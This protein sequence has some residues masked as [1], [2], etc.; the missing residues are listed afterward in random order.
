MVANPPRIKP[1]ITQ[2]TSNFTQ[3]HIGPN[4]D[5]VQQMLDILGLSS[6]DDLIDKTVPQ[7]IRFHQT[8]NLPA[9]QSEY[10]ALG[11]LKQIADKNQ[12]YRSF[13]GMG[14]YDCIT[15]AVIQRN[16][17]ENPG[18]YT[19][20]TPY[21]PEIAQGRLEALL[22]FQT[23]I[24]DLTGLEIANAS[25]LDEGTAAAEAM[26]MSYGVC[27]NKSHNYFVS[28]ECHPQT[29]DVLQTRAKP[30]GINIIIGDH[31][32][33]DFSETIF[34]AILQY[35]A[36]DGTIHDYR[37]FITKSHAQGALVTVAAD[38]LSL[39][40]LTPPGE[41]GTDI[42]VGSTQRFGI[43]LGFGGPHAAYFAT[44]EEYKRLVPGRIIGVS[45]DVNGKPALR[46]ALQTREQHIRRD[47]ATSNICTAQVLL[48][49]MA[50]MYAVYHGPDG[51]RAIAQNI[52]ELTATLAA[53]LKKLGYKISSENFF[54]TLRVELGNTKLDAI[55]DAANERNINLRI[56]DNST[57]GISL[58]ETTTEADLIDIW[59]IFALKD[60]LPF[61][62]KELPVSNSQLS[63]QS[64]YLTHP[65]FNRYHSETELLRYLHQLESK[66]LSLTTS[67]IPLGSCTMKL[68]ATSEMIPVTWAEFGKIHPFAP[69]SQTRGYQ[70]LFQQ[71]EAWLGEI[72]GFAGIS[73]QPNAGSQ[74]E[75]AG[76]LVIHEY[77]QSRGEGHRNIC[78]I[79]QSAH[80][81]NPASAVMCGMKVVG[82]AC[83]DH[84]NIDV[85]DLKAKAEKH[86]SELS[87]LMVTYPSTHGV[88]EEAI[89]E[90]CAIIHK[91]G[92][93]VY[94]DGANM[95][96][97]VGICRPGDIG[98]DVCHL[99]LHKTFCIP[100]GG[101]GPGMGP[102]GVASHLVPFLPGHSVVRMGG[103]LGAVS[104]AP[105]GSASILVI[106]WMYIIMMGADGLTEAT[107]I[108]ILNANYMAKKLESYYP[109]L[110]QGKNGLVAHECILDLRSLKKSA[111]IEIDD[112]AKRLM[113]YGFHA[114]TVSWPVAGTIMVEPT[115]SESKQELDRFC[116]ALIA[117]RE[118]VAAI[119][120]GKMDIEDNVLK[121]AP[122]TAESLIVG[123]WNHPYSREQAAYPAPWNKEYKF[124]PS[125]GR[126]DAAFGDRNF[127]CSCLPMEAYS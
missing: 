44:K 19:A 105:W 60:Q 17:L 23:M 59:Q 76:L 20:Y 48:A 86:S 32:T 96:A 89:Q 123:E 103:D 35:P 55:L 57:V 43:P 14:Y 87:A 53:G 117:I 109:V 40:L 80:G 90:I 81:T 10:A 100:H 84:G 102:I 120:S 98:A 115:E 26:S 94:M 83:D 125:V 111:H 42:A 1:N 122:H 101:G 77:H 15:P 88:F 112:V 8:L 46:L 67:M 108:A 126:I 79:P 72:T 9:A 82:V 69:I 25:L 34:G 21:Q 91:H 47:K 107:K 116:D 18:W 3:R 13:I 70:I 29:I 71:L 54:D 85:D 61:A 49:V 22:N 74:G 110:Y 51:L 2:K 33:F 24:I 106:S 127:V 41:L 97:Q 124:W 27:K 113:D 5:D 78:L 119:E 12:V 50:S 66:D 68:N 75:Y 73:L 16:I 93:Q 52:H 62:A 65:V 92:G 6:I 63:R 45:K 121:N 37:N 7:G 4:S 58:D 56:F 11:M 28:S 104:A 30:L 36:T 64:K 39:T 31:Q 118:E 95:N 114:P 38:P 99:N